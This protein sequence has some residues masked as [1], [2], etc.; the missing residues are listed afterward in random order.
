MEE[1]VPQQK[2][3]VKMPGCGHEEGVFFAF[4]KQSN[5]FEAKNIDKSPQQRIQ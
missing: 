5:P 3:R 2:Y 4:P 1:C